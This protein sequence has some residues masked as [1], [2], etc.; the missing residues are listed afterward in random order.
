MKTV[1]LADRLRPT[2][3]SEVCGQQHILGE[4]RLL[5]KIADSGVIPNLIFFGPSG[6]GKTTV[7]RIIAKIA[8]KKL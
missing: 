3:L 1:P 7:A 4:G 5:R 6:T 2:E 8:N